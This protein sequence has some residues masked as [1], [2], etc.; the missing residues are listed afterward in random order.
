MLFYN[1]C[2]LL[3]KYN[4]MD[5]W[6]LKLVSVRFTLFLFLSSWER[7]FS[8]FLFFFQKCFCKLFRQFLIIFFNYNLM[9]LGILLICLI[10][11]KWKN[12]VKLVNYCHIQG[13]YVVYY[14]WYILPK[15]SSPINR[16]NIS[17]N[18]FISFLKIMKDC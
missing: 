18:S 3:K 16:A 6:L 11:C 15:I 7:Q 14:N 1:L 5:E 13:W 10:I 8:F 9:L 2:N 12:S 4:S 17:I